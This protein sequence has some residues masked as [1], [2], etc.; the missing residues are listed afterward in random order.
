MNQNIAIGRSYE[1][2]AP[3][4]AAIHFTWLDA[5]AFI[6]PALMCVEVKI[7]GRL[8]G[9]DIFLVAILP[10]LLLSR[11]R[12]LTPRLPMTVLRLELLWLARQVATDVCRGTP[13]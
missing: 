12:L 13:F 6:A 11:W 9:S 10:L 5:A 8:F 7:V 1:T 2:L 3:A 4:R